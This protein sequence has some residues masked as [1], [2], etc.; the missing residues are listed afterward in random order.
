MA[1]KRK[2]GK[3]R[4]PPTGGDSK[5]DYTFDATETFDDSEDE[6]FAG[7]DKILLDEGPAAK[8]RR[9]MEEQEKD[10]QPSDEE[11]YQDV[12]SEP[13]SEDEDE[14][15]GAGEEDDQFD[16]DL[17]YELTG[18][19]TRRK[20]A[21]E[22]DEEDEDDIN[23]GTSKAD[24]YNADVIETEADALEEEA[25]ARRLQ[26][27]QLKSMTEADFGFDESAWIDESK[28]APA[29]R[30]AAVEK[31]PDLQVPETATV[32]ERLDMLRTRYPEF[33]PLSKDFLRLQDT[34]Q[35]LKKEAAQSE[36]DRQ[37]VS[38]TKFRA[39]SAY[40]GAVAMYL[41]LL[42]S[43]KSG[44]ALP[45][46]ELREHPIMNNLVRCR[47]LW[48]KAEALRP[49]DVQTVPEDHSLQPADEKKQE[50][51]VGVSQKQKKAK[52][53]KTKSK[54]KK[55]RMS[56]SRSPSPIPSMSEFFPPEAE[57][58]QATKKKKSRKP[59]RN[60]LQ[61]LLET[62]LQQSANAADD[63]SDFG[64]EGPLTQEE[65]AEKAR[66]KKSLRFY[67][68]QIAQKANKR[69]AA[70]RHAGG[71]D[72]VPYKER[73]RDKQERLMREAEQRG[74]SAARGQEALDG[75]DSGDDDAGKG[76]QL[77]DEASQYYDMLVANKEQK[78]AEKRARAEAYAEA[79]R[80]GAGA[81]VYEE[82]QI[83]PDGKRK[84]TYAI[85]KNKGLA[86]RRKKEVRNPRVKK[87]KKFD[88]KMKKLA[89]IRPVYKGG[90][91]RG[92]YGGEATGIKTNVVKSIKL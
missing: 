31:L 41:A 81:Q 92:G 18:R 9:R 14:D 66:R 43:T 91:G 61:E 36:A 45:P 49:I 17:E 68:S 12:G 35:T 32:E 86:P 57:V 62:S 3:A 58:K 75:N 64:D 11:V 26:Q 15:E 5:A 83:G 33:E 50:P 80:Q 27:K 48:L 30:V 42:T 56:I 8:R 38:W 51:A 46:A 25:E 34:Y 28:Q 63:E 79:A 84:I 71:D 44:M 69:G 39:L 70:S 29:K 85:E 6:F 20:E 77:N 88:E 7:R 2:A 53:E 1:K 47:D 52:K 4:A 82:E 73:L 59:K 40:L 10:L 78:K 65:A 74:K 16:D 87:R 21:G 67:T 13:E 72:D 24:Y 23:W 19:K 22:E 90:E 55:E 76:A 37:S 54:S 89:S 60:D